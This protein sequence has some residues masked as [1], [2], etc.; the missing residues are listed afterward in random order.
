MLSNELKSELGLFLKH[1]DLTIFGENPNIISLMLSSIEYEFNKYPNLM[2]CDIDSIKDSIRTCIYLGLI[3]GSVYHQIY[4]FSFKDKNN[5]IICKPIIGYRG[6]TN[7]LF[8][9]NVV[10]K[11]DTHIVYK[12]DIFDIILGT[13]QEI[14]H[15]PNILSK[16]STI[17]AAYTIIKLNSNETIIE[18]LPSRE[19]DI[20]KN[21]SNLSIAWT[22][23]EGE[24]Y[25]KTCL[26]RAIKRINFPINQID[27]L[28]IIQE[29]EYNTPINKTINESRSDVII[30]NRLKE[31]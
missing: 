7:I 15:K 25:K 14:F 30:K 28:K 27:I 8:R 26:K 12:D 31:I 22:I 11:I 23:Y 2:H 4:F 17:I 18:I 13:K 19:A 24:M 6:L 20:I 10:K 16:D 1:T 21:N 3:P 29:E 5:N 9:L